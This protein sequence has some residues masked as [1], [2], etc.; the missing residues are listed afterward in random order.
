[1]HIERIEEFAI[2]AEGEALVCDLLQQSF[3]TYPKAQSYFKLR[4]HFRYLA[5]SDRLLVG[6]MGVDHR[7]IR[8]GDNAYTTFGVIDL[9][10]ASPFQRRG[11]ASHLLKL[12]EA[13]AHETAR[14]AIML[15]AD[16][17]RIYQ[18]HGYQQV[19]VA[20]TWMMVSEHQTRGIAER[21]PDGYVLVKPISL[22]AW[23]AGS[24]DLLGYLY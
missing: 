8:V 19:D 3:P 9:C 12:L 14:D 16:D 17:P 1:M 24:V 4:P 11:L 10:I 15:F 7:V 13:L 6:H 5:W 22:P 20:C 2:T 21:R 18:A 23:P